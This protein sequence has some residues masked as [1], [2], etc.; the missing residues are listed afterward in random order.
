MNI[1][2][3][4][5]QTITNWFTCKVAVKNSMHQLYMWPVVLL[6]HC[7]SVHHRPQGI[8]CFFHHYFS[9]Q[10]KRT[11]TAESTAATFFVNSQ[12]LSRCHQSWKAVPSRLQILQY[13]MYACFRVAL[14]QALHRSQ[15]AAPQLTAH[16]LGYSGTPLGGDYSQSTQDHDVPWVSQVSFKH[17]QT[18]RGTPDPPMQTHHGAQ[19]IH[20]LQCVAPQLQGILWDSSSKSNL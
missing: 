2:L 18:H 5:C 3:Y 1:E 20:F 7:L 6:Q 15:P 9:K 8:F 12:L 14:P 10:L 4:F 19:F 13:C 17:T 16:A 11:N